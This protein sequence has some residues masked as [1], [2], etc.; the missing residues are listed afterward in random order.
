MTRN[1][2]SDFGFFSETLFDYLVM[3]ESLCTTANV[4][5]FG[6]LISIVVRFF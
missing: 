2:I 5:F 4:F 1:P 6:M 3:Y